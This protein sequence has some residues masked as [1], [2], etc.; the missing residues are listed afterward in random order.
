M[1]DHVPEL[2]FGIEPEDEVLYVSPY[3]PEDICEAAANP[4]YEVQLSE[5]YRS[6]ARLQNAMQQLTADVETVINQH[7]LQAVEIFDDLI[8][9][10]G[11]ID[12]LEKARS[13]LGEVYECN[14]GQARDVFDML[15]ASGIELTEPVEEE[16]STPPRNVP[17]GVTIH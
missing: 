16:T 5:A 8:L 17:P 9:V 15:A 3:S 4:D 14:M 1:T 2:P 11:S 12:N 7:D 10:S 6:A 13:A